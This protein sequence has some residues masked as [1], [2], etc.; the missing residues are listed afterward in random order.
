MP[1]KSMMTVLSAMLVAVSI[2]A[3]GC[4]RSPRTP[5]EVTHEATSFKVALLTPGSVS[6]A[7]WNAAA[8]DGMQHVKDNLAAVSEVVQTTS[9]ADA[10]KALA[11][12]AS[13]GFNLIFA[14]G[15]EYTTP[16]LKVA[17]AFPRTVFVVTSGG[18]SSAN[19]ASL[20]FK[21]EEAAY[22]EGMLA[23]SMSKSGI[24]GAVGGGQIPGIKLAFDGFTRGFESI[25]PR[26]KVL[27]SFVG[28]LDDVPA[29]KKAALDQIAQHA[30]LLI[31]NADAASLGV[32]LAARQAHVYAFG[33]HRGQ[34][35][36]APDV[37]LADAVA[38][39]PGAFLRVATQVKAGTF[40]PGMFEM[41]MKEGMVKVVYNEKLKDRVPETAIAR[42]SAAEKD[43]IDGKI[44]FAP[45]PLAQ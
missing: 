44:T 5:D 43:I 25:N 28:R 3:L 4:K 2:A 8:F 36:L 40:K 29:A 15:Y 35:S 42:A 20:V 33:S 31:G 30:D 37:V 10:E 22:V 6:D 18:A 13:R 34:T 24:A 27:V 12:F 7:G 39:I 21:L 23:A 26:G 14:H 16:T 32:F 17:V 19:V 41:G 38:D 45:P 11:D 1:H 9:P